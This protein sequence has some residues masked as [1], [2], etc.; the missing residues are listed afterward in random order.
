MLG[1]W[2]DVEGA[3]ILTGES[4]RAVASSGFE[5]T[6]GVILVPQGEEIV[7]QPVQREERASQRPGLEVPSQSSL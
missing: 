7:E 4:A 5:K 2:L 3:S 1:A 6:E